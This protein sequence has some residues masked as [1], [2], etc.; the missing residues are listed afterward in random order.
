MAAT[1]LLRE[2]LARMIDG[3]DAHLPFDVAVRDFPAEAINR[4]APNVPYTPWHLLEHI[5]LTQLDIL[6]FIRD[7][8]YVERPWPTGYWP[9]P[10]T[11]ADNAAWQRTLHDYLAD[12]A[13]L[14]RI[15]LDPATDL[16][17]PLPAG[18]KY[19]LLREILVVADHTA[20]HIG[21]FGILRQV[22]STWPPGHE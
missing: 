16:C 4:R 5:R 12:R 6:D 14:E 2:Q 15:V 17:A 19:T 9:V 7:P 22:M 20:Y 8:N 21:E 1:D 3:R 11:R 10:G 13:A 18:D